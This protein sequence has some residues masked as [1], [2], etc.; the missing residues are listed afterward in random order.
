MRYGRPIP[1][2]FDNI[3]KTDFERQC[4]RMTYYTRLE[5]FPGNSIRYKFV[6]FDLNGKVTLQKQY[7]CTWYTV[8][9]LYMWRKPYFK[10]RGTIRNAQR[11]YKFKNNGI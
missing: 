6:S 5:Y 1:L 3:I 10:R 7:F 2:V 11:A 9:S 4:L 8:K